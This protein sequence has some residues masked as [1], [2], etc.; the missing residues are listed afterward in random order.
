MD[1][2][3]SMSTEGRNERLKTFAAFSSECILLMKHSSA[4]SGHI[5]MR[6]LGPMRTRN[7]IKA[8]VDCYSVV[9]SRYC[10]LLEYLSFLRF[11]R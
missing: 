3:R 6:V 1:D 10:Y 5:A 2:F 4:L 7:S 8:T 11:R 9:P